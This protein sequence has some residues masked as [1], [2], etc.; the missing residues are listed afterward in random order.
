MQQ[1]I[2]ITQLF[3]DILGHCYFEERWACP[4]MPGHT[5]K[6]LH[7]LTIASLSSHYIQKMSIIPQIVCDIK[8]EKILK[9]D[10]WRAYQT[11]FLRTRLFSRYAVFTKLYS[12]L[13][14]SC[15]TTKNKKRTNKKKQKM[16]PSLNSLLLAHWSKF[17]W[18]T[19]LPTQ[20]I[21]FSKIQL[22]TF[23]VYMACPHAKN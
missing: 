20:Q 19:Q 3:P 6:I 8:L 23:L 16:V 5:E 9:Y 10:W 15:K 4:S 12:Q 11:F 1:I 7:D 21:Q 17:V 18:S 2:K 14:A 22:C 13:W